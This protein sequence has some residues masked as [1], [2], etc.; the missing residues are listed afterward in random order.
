MEDESNKVTT[1][2]KSKEEIVKKMEGYILKS[3]HCI[4]FNLNFEIMLVQNSSIKK[5]GGEICMGERS[6]NSKGIPSIWCGQLRP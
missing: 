1:S 2:K 6:R 5:K 3:M 4:W